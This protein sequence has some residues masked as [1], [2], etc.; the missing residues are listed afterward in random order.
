MKAIRAASVAFLLLAGIGISFGHEG[1]EHPGPHGG[2]LSK[3]GDQAFEVVFAATSIRVYPLTTDLKP[4]DT[5][6]LSGSVTF[7]H[8]NVPD[9]PWFERPL[10]VAAVSGQAPDSLDLSLD[11]SSVPATGVKLVVSIAGFPDPKAPKATITVPYAPAVAP[12]PATLV[13]SAATRADGPAIA[14]QRVCKVSGKPLG[15]MGGPIKVSLGSRSTFICC[16]SCLNRVAANPDAYLPAAAPAATTE[17]T[18][19]KATTADQAAINAQK[20]CPVSHEDLASMGGPLKVSRGNQS[21]FICCQSCA[22]EI[23]A[24]PDKYL[25]ASR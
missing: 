1:H 15:S 8:S 9:K 13:Y 17:I 11:M 21:V 12:A 2:T 5:T 10:A 22:K 7:Y 20:V 25:T 23:K 18:I 3:S 4:I 19:A 6:R 24:N 16:Q 14:A